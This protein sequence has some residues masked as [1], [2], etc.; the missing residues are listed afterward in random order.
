MEQSNSS[1]VLVTSSAPFGPSEVFFQ[2]EAAEIA[3]DH[4]LILA[5]IW[6]RGVL[7]LE[8]GTVLPA[9]RKQP[10]HRPMSVIGALVRSR[11]LRSQLAST[12]RS[13]D[14]RTAVKCLVAVWIGIEWGLF[15]VAGDRNV[16]HVH[17]STIGAP[18]AG[19][20]AIG[21]LL[22]V[23]VSATAH[24][25]DINHHAPV[26]TLRSMLAI[27]AITFRAQGRLKALQ[28]HSIV[29]RL[30][31]L[32]QKEQTPAGPI[33]AP[34]KCVAI[35]SLLPVKGIHRS[36]EMIRRA[37]AAGIEVS[38]DIV[39]DGPMRDEL[40]A[41][42]D[43]SGCDE[44][45]AL[46]GHLDHGELLPQLESGRW[47][48]LI[49]SSIAKGTL[50]EGLPVAVLEAASAG[51]GIIATNSGGTREFV[52]DRV[53]GFLIDAE[54]DEAAIAQ[55][56]AIL[57]ELDADP[58]LGQSLGR[59]AMADSKAFLAKTTLSQLRAAIRRRTV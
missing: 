58:S 1:V 53:N 40:A 41:Q 17:A 8:W 14:I 22:G 7:A 43:Q 44:F 49:Q 56:V 26:S 4:N 46:L 48:T 37:R 34:L 15:F 45:V 50:E 30:G 23:P 10:P 16:C 25:D 18:S 39:G 47:N 27:R 11:Q 6:P 33:T 42:I 20:S 51:L 31:S 36:I 5:P 12:I 57:M 29:I 21:A 52:V 2:A 3:R 24:R 55:G 38:L 19:A 35:G 59:A 54:D 13:A 32:A 28:I 9:G